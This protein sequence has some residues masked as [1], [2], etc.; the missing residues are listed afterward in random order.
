MIKK[1]FQIFFILMLVFILSGSIFTINQS[2][3]PM[4]IKGQEI[5]NDFD[6]NHIENGWIK[7]TSDKNL[8]L[9]GTYTHNLIDYKSNLLSVSKKVGFSS[10]ANLNN[11][12]VS[13]IPIR[14]YHVSYVDNER[15][16]TLEKSLTQY[17]NLESKD[18]KNFQMR[19][20]ENNGEYVCKIGFGT[21]T[22]DGVNNAIIVTGGDSGSPILISDIATADNINGW[23]Q[24]FENGERQYTINCSLY[25]GNGTIHGYLY[26]F[27][28]T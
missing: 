14:Y 9:I 6:I 16:L 17:I 27:E 26:F 28:F 4:L 7:D 11:Y 20:F 13:T 25:I 24:V 21:V 10:Y 2:F 23:N 5:G 12:N 3:N 19:N 18:V 1:K 8:S 22:F 15:V